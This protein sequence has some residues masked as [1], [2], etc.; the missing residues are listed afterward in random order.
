MASLLDFYFQDLL[1]S[2]SYDYNKWLLC[3][4]ILHLNLMALKI[5]VPDFLNKLNV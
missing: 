1:S 4:Y 5:V 2:V 3:S